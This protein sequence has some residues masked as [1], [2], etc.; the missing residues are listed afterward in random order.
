MNLTD[1]DVGKKFKTREGKTATLE[2][3]GW[4]DGYVY[5]YFYTTDETGF[6]AVTRYGESC[7]KRPQ[8][9]LVERVVEEEEK[10]EKKT[11]LEEGMSFTNLKGERLHT[12]QFG[13]GK[14]V[15]YAPGRA[16]RYYDDVFTTVEQVEKFL[17]IE[18]VRVG[19]KVTCTDA[20]GWS[21]LA[22][23]GVYTV[24]AIDEYGHYKL[25]GK[26]QAPLA[27]ADGVPLSWLSPN[28]HIWTAKF[29][30]KSTKEEIEAAEKVEMLPVGTFIKFVRN[31]RSG[32]Y[33]KGDL[34][35]VV[36]HGQRS[37][38]VHKIGSSE[39]IFLPPDRAD[40]YAVVT[41]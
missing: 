38:C 13:Y 23:G 6:H 1:A 35:Q 26:P 25:S 28:D 34:A 30:R 29:F 5:P 16:N 22:V 24:L 17:G 41:V 36:D 37:M 27:T 15:L 12:F 31:S 3:N 11:P 14:F 8:L 4:D 33:K 40:I 9:D 18:K 19:D 7:L 10:S 32:R 20:H 21:C 2:K 39:G